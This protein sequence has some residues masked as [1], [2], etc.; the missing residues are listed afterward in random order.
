MG[1]FGLISDLRVSLE[2]LSKRSFHKCPNEI[3]YSSLYSKNIP[4][5]VLSAE[6]T[7]KKRLDSCP[8]G[9]HG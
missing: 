5:V 2:K 6:D 1:F 3:F 4:N 9:A 7:K 8:N